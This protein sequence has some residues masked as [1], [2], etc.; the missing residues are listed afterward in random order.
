MD[1]LMFIKLLG[2]EIMYTCFSTRRNFSTKYFWH[3]ALNQRF[4]NIFQTLQIGKCNQDFKWKSINL[5]YLYITYIYCIVI[6]YYCCCY[7][8]HFVSCARLNLRSASDLRRN[9]LKPRKD[10]RDVRR[11]SPPSATLGCRWLSWA[12]PLAGP[13]GGCSALAALPPPPV[14]A[15]KAALTF[16]LPLTFEIWKRSAIVMNCC[17]C[18]CYCWWFNLNFVYIFLGTLLYSAACFSTDNCYCTIPDYCYSAHSFA[19]H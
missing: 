14:S 11:L 7:V 8:T 17:C 1:E 6:L 5:V 3:G 16:A 15:S 19:L 10:K 4:Q 13:F 2:R 18:R 12:G 9:W